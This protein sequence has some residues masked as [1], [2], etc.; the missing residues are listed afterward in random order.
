MSNPTN[1]L[2][3]QLNEALEEMKAVNEELRKVLSQ[4]IDKII[5]TQETYAKIAGSEKELKTF[6]DTFKEYADFRNNKRNIGR[7][8]LRGDKI[9][10]IMNNPNYLK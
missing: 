9:N 7:E 4:A 2:N 8:P 5:E 6:I 10:S 3:E 1:D